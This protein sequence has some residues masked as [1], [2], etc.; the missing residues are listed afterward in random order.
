MKKATILN[1]Y[2]TNQYPVDKYK[3]LISLSLDIVENFLLSLESGFNYNSIPVTSYSEKYGS[4][5]RNIDSK[6]ESLYIKNMNTKEEMEKFLDSFFG[7]YNSLSEEEQN[8]FNATFIEGLT[9]LEIMEKYNTH[10]RY[11][12]EVRKSTIV[13]FC[14]KSGLDKFV[15]VI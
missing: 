11:I 10:C 13:R 6:I 15:D 5:H 14:L 12:R 3:K 7:A 2:I 8:I 4:F 9:D 1:E